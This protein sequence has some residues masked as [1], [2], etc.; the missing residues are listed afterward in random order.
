M[1][2]SI[3]RRRFLK[4]SLVTGGACLTLNTR[5]WAGDEVGDAP[6]PK[7]RYKIGVCDWMMLKRQKL[8]AF[9]L[10][11]DV[12]ADGV[13]VDMGSL[14]QRESFENAL[15][16]PA[17]R[18]QF[19]DAARQN[20]LEI[21]SLAMSAF[22]AQSFGDRPTVPQMLGDCI[23][24]MKAMAVKVAFLP[25]GVRGDL[26]NY[27]Q[28]RPA[29]VERLKSIAPVAEKAGVVIGLE[30]ALD[31]ANEVKLLEEI[32]SPAIRIYFNFENAIQGKRDLHAEIRTLG[33]D[34]IC[35]IHCTDQDG[36]LLQ[37]NPRI[38]M[39]K[40]KQTLDEMNWSGWL[41]IERS[42]DARDSRNVRRNF[43]ANARYLK[44]VFQTS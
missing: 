12:G 1:N 22:Y 3:S 26:V 40:V 25:L 15:A 27:P 20:H 38:D 34:R 2:R 31:A 8:G 9:P 28:L 4:G 18:K 32:A 6:T 19:M 43:G 21:C 44:S 23:E 30:T 33:K 41:V 5:A 14:G 10:A 13:E 29:I 17:V 42:R 7:H 35:Q 36:V 39:A 11:K 24:M 16:D 37:D